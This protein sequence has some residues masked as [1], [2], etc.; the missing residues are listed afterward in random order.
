MVKEI[1]S[2]QEFEAEVAYSG[3]T[4]VD[5]FATWCGPCK[6]IAPIL[7]KLETENGSVH[8]VK[9]DVDAVPDVAAKNEISAM[10][11]IKFFKNGELVDTVVGA[12]VPKLRDNVAKLQ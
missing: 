12:N 9:V 6:M 10:P 3:L 1:K 4:V 11:T 2:L 7:D 5:F 8:F